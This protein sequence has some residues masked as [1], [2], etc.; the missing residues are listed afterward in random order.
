MNKAFVGAIVTLGLSLVACNNDLGSFPVGVP[1]PIVSFTKLSSSWNP[2]TGA[3]SVGYTISARTI[4]GSPNGT[5][6]SF[7]SKSG[8]EFGIGLY[9]EACSVGLQKVCPA[10]ASGDISQSFLNAKQEDFI[11]TGLRVQGENGISKVIAWTGQQP[12]LPNPG[13]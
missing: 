3:G 8:R 2:T 13:I 11:F 7:V 6:Q 1:T 9:V 10:S 5:V 12:V 4:P